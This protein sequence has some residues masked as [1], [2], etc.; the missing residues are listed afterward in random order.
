M[1][2]PCEGEDKKW[3][4]K[5]RLGQAASSEFFL[6]DVLDPIDAGYD[7][8]WNAGSNKRAGGSE[9]SSEEYVAATAKG[10]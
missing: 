1:F 6:P 3:D 5:F 4:A 7:G 8:R 9:L 10:V 2:G